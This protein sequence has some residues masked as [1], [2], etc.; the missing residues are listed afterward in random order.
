MTKG[1]EAINSLQETVDSIVKKKSCK[2]DGSKWLAQQ[3]YLAA[4]TKMKLPPAVINGGE[5]NK[6]AKLSI[7]VAMKF[8]IEWQLSQQRKD[9]KQ[10]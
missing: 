8:E 9:E 6:V 4:V 3:V 1:E 7:Q 10:Q 2:N 5:L